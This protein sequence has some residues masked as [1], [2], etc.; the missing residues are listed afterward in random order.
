[1]KEIESDPS[2]HTP[3]DTCRYVGV[4]VLALLGCFGDMAC[5]KP[6]PSNPKPTDGGLLT[7]RPTPDAAK[8][9]SLSEQL[10]REFGNDKSIVLLASDAGIVAASADGVRQRT[11]VPGRFRE[12][13]VD[14]RGQVAWLAR[15]DDRRRI[16]TFEALDL[17]EPSPK[18]VVVVVATHDIGFA[19]Q[20]LYSDP[21]EKLTTR[22][23]PNLPAHFQLR[24]DEGGVRLEC[25]HRH[26]EV[27]FSAES[28]EPGAHPGVKLASSGFRGDSGAQGRS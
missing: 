23:D 6:N 26:D 7:A 25:R 11:V 13:V 12:M 27:P 19:V 15:M 17:T 24:I 9:P 22:P 18:P 21:V 28:A 1:M 10:H 16:T 3:G 8:L 14:P 20:I 2:M 5:S 4:C